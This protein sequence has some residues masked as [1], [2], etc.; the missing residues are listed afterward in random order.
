MSG[1]DVIITTAATAS[2]V[3]KQ[4]E[5][6]TPLR[7]GPSAPPAPGGHHRQP[8]LKPLRLPARVPLGILSTSHVLSA[9]EEIPLPTLLK[10]WR[11][12]GSSNNN[13][14]H[15]AINLFLHWLLI[16]EPS[17]ALS[18][19]GRSVHLPWGRGPW[20][21]R[22]QQGASVGLKR[23]NRTQQVEG[24]RDSPCRLAILA[25]TAKPRA[26]K[27]TAL[28]SWTRPQRVRVSCKHPD[29]P[30]KHARNVHFAHRETFLGLSF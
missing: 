23:G 25:L 1:T 18:S 28:S 5:V 20:G 30:K 24:S 29:G 16:C 21:W 2:A 13:K 15:Q 3:L 6:A 11:K 10:P 8:S 9:W 14:K 19:P 4:L 22:A 26:P 12:T 7:Q 17:S 27:W